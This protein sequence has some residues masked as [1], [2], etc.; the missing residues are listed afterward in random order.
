V[1]EDA[2]QNIS[3]AEGVMAEQVKG[4]QVHTKASQKSVVY[5]DGDEGPFRCD[6]CSYFIKPNACK[7][8]EGDIDPAG[9]CNLY[10]KEDDD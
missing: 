8:V 6:H 4:L 1:E 7:I 2:T 10:S 5:M 9:C 3:K